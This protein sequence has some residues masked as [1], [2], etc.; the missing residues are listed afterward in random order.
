V[1]AQFLEGLSPA[2]Q[3]LSGRLAHKRIGTGAASFVL[4]E[5]KRRKETRAQRERCYRVG[6]CYRV[7]NVTEG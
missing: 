3:Q 1:A 2:S 4:T 7:A 5:A 6:E